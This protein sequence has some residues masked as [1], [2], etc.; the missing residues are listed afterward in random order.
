MY[1]ITCIEPR[2]IVDENG[3]EKVIRYFWLTIIKDFFILAGGLPM[4]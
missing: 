3:C 4:I 2:G 1:Y